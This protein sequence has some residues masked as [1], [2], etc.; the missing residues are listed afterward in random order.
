MGINGLLPVVKPICER[1][2][3]DTFAQRRV[4]V[5]ASGWLHRGAFSCATELAT[6]AP[7][8]R[9]INYCM[10]RVRMLL[11]FGA[12]PVLVFDGAPLP[13]KA[14]T[15]ARRRELRDDARK[16]GLAAICR[17]DRAAAQDCFQRATEITHEMARE[18]IKELRKLN[19]EY[20]VAPYEADAQLAWLAANDHVDLIV[21]E[22]SDLIVY[23]ASKILYKLS[24]FGEGELFQ[25]K[26]LPALDDPDLRNFSPQMITWICV[27]SGCDFFGGVPG[28]GIRKAHA[29]VKRTRNL[30]RLLHVIRYD[31]RYPVPS[32]FADD[33]HRACLV[34]KHQTVFDCTKHENV[35]LTPLD[36][37]ARIS[38]PDHIFLSS[39]GQMECMDFVGRIHD[40]EIAKGIAMG[41]IHPATLVN[42][43]EP[44]DVIE[45]A[46]LLKF[47]H[48]H[49]GESGIG[50][51]YSRSAG[52]ANSNIHTR[53][54]SV[55]RGRSVGHTNNITRSLFRPFLSNP[56]RQ[57]H[58][59]SSPAVRNPFC[60][61]KRLQPSTNEEEN[62]PCEKNIDKDRS[63]M[64]RSL[65]KI[66]PGGVT[67]NTKRAKQEIIT[68]SSKKRQRTLTEIGERPC[69]VQY[70]ASQINCF[71]MHADIH[72]GTVLVP[73][74]STRFQS[75]LP[76]RR[77]G[78]T[79]SQ[80]EASTR[81]K[82]EQ[83][84]ECPSSP[85]AEAYTQFAAAEVESDND[86]A[87]VFANIGSFD[88]P[89]ITDGL[90]K[91]MG[92]AQSR[93]DRQENK[94]PGRV[95]QIRVCSPFIENRR[96]TLPPLAEQLECVDEDKTTLSVADEGLGG[97]KCLDKSSLA[98]L[99]R[100]DAFKR[101]SGSVPRSSARR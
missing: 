61:P 44:L 24:K 79:S 30:T 50:P 88:G 14:A 71:A 69:R 11:H 37:A 12:I 86:E 55:P 34:F 53:S 41:T 84:T 64:T 60:P 92:S 32:D 21:T 13:M 4:G 101:L 51:S 25:A 46:P 100:L 42:S 16:S 27:L 85:D 49:G 89:T 28:L 20:Y 97:R 17:G 96:L 87:H 40:P 66:N 93:S 72:I 54:A 5:D 73:A 36:A 52:V 58:I 22:D 43:L 35:H 77:L 94:S 31:T 38:V 70:A 2:H 8:R 23:G 48:A 63:W 99:D 18:L 68:S 10:H 91:R 47:S 98:F 83:V 29:L 19:V 6:G 1:K 15:N 57:S 67:T 26:N 9:Y 76:R 95:S 82:T 65:S 90:L 62:D 39:S 81:E 80:L 56:T 45:R 75:D 78:D 59:T 3:I 7:T 74:D 33:F